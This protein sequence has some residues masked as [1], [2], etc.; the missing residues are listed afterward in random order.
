MFVC[1]ASLAY[2]NFP[3]VCTM[4]IVEQKGEDSDVM[5]CEA[6]QV[7]ID[8][9]PQAWDAIIAH[10]AVFDPEQDIDR[11]NASDRRMHGDVTSEELECMTV[12]TI[13]C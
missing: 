10:C 7:A 8:K 2:P 13:R 12:S 6:V 3:E 5:Y 11:L 4:Q 9:N 1:L